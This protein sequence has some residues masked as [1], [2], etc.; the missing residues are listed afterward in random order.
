MPEVILPERKLMPVRKRLRY[1]ELNI[2]ERERALD[3]IPLEVYRQKAL[4]AEPTGR[5]TDLIVDKYFGR[6]FLSDAGCVEDNLDKF[7]EE[8]E[9][10]C[11][12]FDEDPAH[13]Y[14][15]PL[16]YNDLYMLQG[17]IPSIAGYDWAWSNTEEYRVAMK[18]KTDWVD[19]G[20]WVYRFGTRFFM[21]EPYA[22][23][24]PEAYD[25]LLEVK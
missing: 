6:T 3:I 4:L 5:G 18:F 19:S 8:Y 24:E 13:E 12:R 20:E 17:V 25:F 21:F 7:I 9:D 16:T 15:D 22:G 10:R 11:R 23:S 1:Q 14:V 2:Q